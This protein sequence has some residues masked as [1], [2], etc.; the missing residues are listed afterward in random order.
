MEKEIVEIVEE[1]KDNYCEKATIS[2][3]LL[4]NLL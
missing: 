4:Q 1:L 3:H 2:I